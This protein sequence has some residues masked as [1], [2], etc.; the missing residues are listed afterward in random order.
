VAHGDV[1]ASHLK[2]FE[3]EYAADKIIKMMEGLNPD[4]FPQQAVFSDGK[5]TANTIPNALKKNELSKLYRRCGEILHR[6]RF[7]TVLSSEPLKHGKL[8]RQEIVL[9]KRSNIYWAL[10]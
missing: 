2:K 7:E 5:I 9:P 8:D 4:F 3:K 1:V 6:G 10:T